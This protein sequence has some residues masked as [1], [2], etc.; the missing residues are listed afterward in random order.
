MRVTTGFS[1]KSY[2]GV[3]FLL[4]HHRVVAFV[5]LTPWRWNETETWLPSNWA[6]FQGF[7]QIRPVGGGGGGGEGRGGR[8]EGGKTIISNVRSL[9]LSEKYVWYLYFSSE[10]C[11]W[12]QFFSRYSTIVSGGIPPFAGR[13]DLWLLHSIPQS[14]QQDI[15]MRQPTDVV[16]CQSAFIKDIIWCWPETKAKNK[17]SMLV[18]SHNPTDTFPSPNSGNEL[19]SHVALNST[20]F[21]LVAVPSTYTAQQ[22]PSYLLQ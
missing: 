2:Q 14:A 20:I 3:W 7:R 6:Y 21:L 9:L 4:D 11:Q 12:L 13:M 16:S 22:I 17:R 1:T 19:Q 18:D 5:V 8:G 10:E 15:R